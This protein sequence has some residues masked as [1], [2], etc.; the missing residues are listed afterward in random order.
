[1]QN[2]DWHW[3]RHLTS[4]EDKSQQCETM[5]AFTTGHKS[6]AAWLHF[7]LQAPEWPCAVPK[8][9]KQKKLL[10]WKTETWLLN[11][12]LST[13]EKLTT[14]AD[15]LVFFPLTS[16]VHTC[17]VLPQRL[18][19]WKTGMRKVGDIRMNLPIFT[20]CNL[21][22]ELICGSLSMESRRFT[23]GE[24]WNHRKEVECRVPEMRWKVEFSCTSTNPVWGDCDQTGAQYSATEKQRTMADV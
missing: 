8:T 13:M 21:L 11:V 14:W 2:F 4:T 12:G 10:T 22:R 24:D 23:V 9:V 18:R 15:F 1:M 3:H 6:V 5:F 16:N 17:Q 7:F 20:S 19:G